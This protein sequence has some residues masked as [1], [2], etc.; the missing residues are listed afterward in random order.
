MVPR[1]FDDLNLELGDFE[2]FIAVATPEEEQQES[3]QREQAETQ[4]DVVEDGD[5]GKA[6]TEDSLREQHLADG[7]TE[8]QVPK[9]KSSSSTSTNQKSDSN[10]G[11]SVPSLTS[12]SSVT[13]GLNGSLKNYNIMSTPFSGGHDGEDVVQ[14]LQKFEESMEM[15]SQFLPVNKRLALLK[16]NLRGSAYNTVSANVKVGSGIDDKT[17]YKQAK[18]VLLDRR[19]KVGE[20]P[21][22]YLTEL[23]RLA[24]AAIPPSKDLLLLSPQKMK[25]SM[26]LLLLTGIKAKEKLKG[27][28]EKAKGFGMERAKVSV[29]RP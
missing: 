7:D 28:K 5:D 27:R 1:P 10:D 9:D 4:E 14:W 26:C 12:T 19:M 6:R 23:Q 8:E 13:N 2:N 3:E 22:E 21:G 16:L 24:S 29:I 11:K 20:T 18:K 17:A 15:L 25:P